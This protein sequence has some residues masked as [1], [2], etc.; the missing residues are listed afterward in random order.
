MGIIG[1]LIV[2]L[3][4]T[5]GFWIVVWVVMGMYCGRRWGVNE[6]GAAAAGVIAGPLGLLLVFLYA[7]RG[8]A[9]GI[10]GGHQRRFGRRNPPDPTLNPTEIPDF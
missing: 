9:A 6:Y 1:G 5:M 4:L 2:I 7:R 8:R 3:A 10:V